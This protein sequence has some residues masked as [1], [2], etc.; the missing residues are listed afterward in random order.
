MGIIDKGNKNFMFKIIRK[1]I[2]WAGS[3][4]KLET[5]KIARQADGAVVVTYGE[6]VILCT[7]VSDKKKNMSQPPS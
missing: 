5:G 4:L 2:E 3:K 7:V 6:T 1:E